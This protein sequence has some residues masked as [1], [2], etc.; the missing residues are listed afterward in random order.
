[1]STV[2]ARYPHVTAPVV[3]SGMRVPLKS[4]VPNDLDEKTQAQAF[5]LTRLPMVQSHV[6]L[7][8]DAH[9]GYGMPI[10][11]VLFTRDAVVPY[12]IGVDIGCGVQIAETNLVWEDN[13]DKQKLKEVLR[14]IQ[15]DI[16]TGF[17][18][19]KIAPVNVQDLYSKLELSKNI[20]I[21]EF[22]ETQDQL[23]APYEHWLNKV[24][25]QLGTLGG[26]NH[27]LEVQRDEAGRVYFMLHSGSRSLGKNI[28]DFYVKSALALNKKWHSELPDSE[29]A[30]LPTGTPE[31]SGYWS[32]MN[33]ALSWAELNRETMT[34]RVHE[35]FKKHASVK[36]F[37]VLTDVHHNYASWE[38]HGKMNG[39]VHRKGAVRARL[40]EMVLIPG[41][42][43]T[44]SYIATG[45]G[46][47]DSFQTCQHGAGRAVGRNAMKKK[48]S[49]DDVF[50]DMKAR[51][52]EFISNEP[53]SAAEEAAQ[54]YKNIDEVIEASAD[55]IKPTVK[56]WPL[57]VV[58]G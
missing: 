41:S 53:E 12:A 52:I 16:P 42:M 28:C 51:G 40:G 15:R 21:A 13:F 34:D 23:N 39:I 54:A 4:W 25:L 14:Q 56:L 1:M 26:G 35:A 30:F 55:L 50:A 45:L 2:T 49:S 20:D 5:N 3:G 18:T 6:A 33:F 24:L 48:M 11:G 37:K 43:G 7:M 31:Y 44:N 32:A 29:L 46:N 8:P 17:S 9:A 38:N 19:H 57:G 10:G 58:K 27:F 36:H 47:S 22:M